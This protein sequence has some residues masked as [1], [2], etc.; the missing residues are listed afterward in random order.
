MFDTSQLLDKRT[1]LIVSWEIVIF[2][3]NFLLC[4][5]GINAKVKLLFKNK[6]NYW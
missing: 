3:L 2:F 6:K 5:M 4:M 1:I